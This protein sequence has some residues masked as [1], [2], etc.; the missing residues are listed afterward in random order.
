ML[1]FLYFKILLHNTILVY[2]CELVCTCK[3]AQLRF[4]ITD[5]QKQ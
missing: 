3:C 1:L 5:I 4:C 2:L